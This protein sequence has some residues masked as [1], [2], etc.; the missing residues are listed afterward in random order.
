MSEQFFE[1][2]SRF[3]PDAGKL[4]R[5]ELLFEAGRRSIRPNRAWK[6]VASV[7]AVT[8]CL[9]LVLLLAGSRPVQ[10]VHSVA[11][12]PAPTPS[13]AERSTASGTSRDRRP[14]VSAK[15]A[16][17]C[18]CRTSAVR[19]GH[20]DGKWT[21]LAGVLATARFFVELNGRTENVFSSPGVIR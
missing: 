1:R 13:F 20:I 16:N 11:H 10:P 15:R 3:T 4:N 14:L 2:L 18:R 19:Q 7:L 21:K 6:S 5:D 9:S 8:Q 17:G 12:D